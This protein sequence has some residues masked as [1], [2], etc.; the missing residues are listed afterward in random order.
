MAVDM[1]T[2]IAVTN[3]S[4]GMV[5]YEVPDLGTKREFNCKETK[6]I[7]Y[8]E[9]VS[10]AQ[11]PGG[12]ELIYNFLFVQDGEAL[13]KALNVEE[14]PEYWLTEEKIPSWM[15]SCSLSEFQD[16]LDFAPEGVKDL[17]KKYAISMPLN[18]ADKRAAIKEQLK[19][20]IDR[21]IEN[22]KDDDAVTVAPAPKV[23]RRSQP[24]YNVVNKQD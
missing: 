4:D 2:L 21:A 7:P 12:R 13:E 24:K 20:D 14:Q 8:K 1:N 11:Q 15:N 23:V 18:A 3:R 19:F 22:A 16:A 10:L 9:L 5:L 6:Q 17:I